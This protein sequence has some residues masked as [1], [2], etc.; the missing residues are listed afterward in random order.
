MKIGNVIASTLALCWGLAVLGLRLAHHSTASG[1]AA[2]SSGQAV[3]LVV[4]LGIGVLG[5]RGLLKEYQ[6]SRGTS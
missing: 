6:R 4:A 5:A 2:F 3:G 1:D